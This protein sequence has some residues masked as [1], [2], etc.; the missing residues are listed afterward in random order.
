MRGKG[1]AVYRDEQ[2]TTTT[3]HRNPQTVTDV[4]TCVATLILYT[5]NLCVVGDVIFPLNNNLKKTNLAV[6]ISK[7][8]TCQSLERRERDV[9]SPTLYPP[10]KRSVFVQWVLGTLWLQYGVLLARLANW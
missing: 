7:M 10:R 5:I 2:S 3:Q 9:P 8:N 1:L 6:C 4:C